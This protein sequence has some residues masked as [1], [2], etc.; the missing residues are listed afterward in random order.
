MPRPKSKKAAPDRGDVARRI[1]LAGVGAYGRAFHEAQGRLSRVGD[2]TGR[3]FEELVERGEAIERTV[4]TK[5]REVAEKLIPDAAAFDARVKRLR[6]RIGIGD[7]SDL[8]ALETRL[9]RI[10]EKLDRLLAGGAPKKPARKPA[11]KKSVR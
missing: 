8:G 2:E 6:R 1:W 3:L 7:E 10:E 4:E 9:D 5:G 11:A